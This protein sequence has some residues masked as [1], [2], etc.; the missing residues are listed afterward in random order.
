M[1]VPLNLVLA[2]LITLFHMIL[3]ETI[4]VVRVVS[5]YGQS[6]KLLPMVIRKWLGSYFWGQW[7]MAMR[8]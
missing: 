2:V 6:I 3:D 7:F 4:L 1:S 5:L 8:V